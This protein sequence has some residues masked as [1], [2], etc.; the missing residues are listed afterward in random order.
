MLSYAYFAPENIRGIDIFLELPLSREYVGRLK[1]EKNQFHFSYKAAYL[2]FKGAKPLDGL[3]FPKKDFFSRQLFQAFEN[4][5][6]RFAKEYSPPPP[7][8]VNY[9]D[10]LITLGTIA[11]TDDKSPF[12]FAPFYQEL[13]VEE[14]EKARKDMGITREEFGLIFDVQLVTLNKMQSGEIIAPDVLKRLGLYLDPLVVKY[15]IAKNGHWIHSKKLKNLL[16]WL[17]SQG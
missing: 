7:L 14:V 12:I 6:A 16:K 2:K 13:T 10:T 15:Q 1:K 17:D 11:K 5:M 8:G 4:R 9:S 3:P